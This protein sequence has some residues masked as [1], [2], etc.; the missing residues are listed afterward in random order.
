MTI[1]V[2]EDCTHNGSTSGSSVDNGSTIRD[3]NGKEI[4]INL[5]GVTGYGQETRP[6]VTVQVGQAY[7]YASNAVHMKNL[8]MRFSSTS[9]TFQLFL[10]SHE[11]ILDTG[12][13]LNISSGSKICFLVTSSYNGPQCHQTDQYNGIG[14]Y[15]SYK[16]DSF[17]GKVTMLDGEISYIIA[18]VG[19]PGVKR[20]APTTTND[21]STSKYDFTD[22]RKADFYLSVGGTAHVTGALAAARYDGS[23]NLISNNFS[24]G[25]TFLGGL[26]CTVHT[27]IADDAEVGSV[28]GVMRGGETAPTVGTSSSS[29]GSGYLDMTHQYFSFEFTMTGGK[30]T[31]SLYPT[32]GN[33][34]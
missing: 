25:K 17:A 11:W 15:S 19:H 27:S 7:V 26:G 13:Q 1:W 6:I 21:N 22:T 24:N 31:S 3:S 29:K 12:S 10:C 30:L 8:E 33:A 4:M 5:T 23:S 2:L 16:E 14:Q 18:S 20:V 32:V 34:A 9:T 28:Y